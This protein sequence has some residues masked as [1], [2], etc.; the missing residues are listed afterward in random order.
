MNASAD[1]GEPTAA[2]TRFGPYIVVEQ[3]G[4]GGM[5]D[6]YRARDTRLNRDVA[7]KVIRGDYS[8]PSSRR[9]FEAEARAVAKL[10]HPNIV[11]IFDVGEERGNP[12]IVQE[13]VGGGTLSRWL[14]ERRPGAADKL[15]L[16]IAIAEGLA[17]AHRNGIVHR[18]LKPDNVLLTPDGRPKISDFGLAKSFQALANDESGGATAV[19]SATREGAFVGTP[20]YVSP[21]QATGAPLDA[22][23]DQFSFASMLVEMFGGRRPFE[24]ATTVQTLAAILHEEPDYGRLEKSV[25]EALLAIIRRCLAKEP[26]RRYG[27]TDDLLHDLR[28]AAEPRVRPAK[29][30]VRTAAFV[31][32]IALLLLAGVF[33]LW[34]RPAP[35]TA[36]IST[37][38]HSLA[39]LPLSNFSGDPSQ[40]YF[41][42]GMTEELT[43]QL[44]SL[45]S[46]RVVSR[47]SASAYRGTTKPL[48]AVAREL[49]VEGLIEGSVIRTGDRA[50]VTVQ[51]IDGRTDRHLWSQ[52]FD[53]QG[54]DVLTM[55]RDVAGQIADRIRAIVTPA[56][57]AR[58][59]RLPT[60]SVVAY[61]AFL[62]SIYKQ[63][64]GIGSGDADQ[65]IRFA[66]QA[67]AAD[68]NFAEAYVALARACQTKIFG[69]NGGKEYDEKGFIAVQKA[70]SL[71]P[72]LPDAYLA[73]GILH[74]NRWHDYDL[75]A[76]IADQRKAI[77][78]NANF[79]DAHHALG[80]DLTHV[81]LHDEAIRELQTAINLDPRMEGPKRRLGRPLWQSGRFTEALAAYERYGFAQFEKA[82]VLGYLGRRDE[83]WRVIDAADGAAPSPTTQ[84]DGRSDIA[85]ARALLYAFEHEREKANVQIRTSAEFGARNPHFHHAAFFL[86]AAC[87]ELS[88]PGEAVH[89]LEIVAS[90]G[91][92][93]LPLFRDNPSMQKL[94]GDPRY[95]RFL[96]DL[97][98][99]W[100]LLAGRETK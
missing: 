7:L 60:G 9:R 93:N 12:Y 95:E 90:T 66:E 1:A 10:S 63:T 49:G 43:S 36:P 40:D 80:A 100:D 68:P 37:Q 62:H 23:S 58:L 54:A 75:A 45:P 94:R 96:A 71:N 28:C 85:A 46:L 21:E 91:M 16:A 99:R 24:R 2:G 87:A 74:Y 35:A 34:H 81:G 78:L 92:P 26:A 13:L 38:P 20:A 53:R 31:T 18:D 61:D 30:S 69:W 84:N 70:L 56:D 50:R 64:T 44:A 42:E 32:A 67:I 17:E 77:S 15:A 39:I 6:V 29:R 55:Q 76:A 89:W 86:A 5:G 4:A 27:S 48:S 97:R 14:A 88:Q 33:F 83:A 22:R 11:S 72:Q 51:M 25:P 47:T 82:V 57:R 52:T 19:A 73:R 59:A 8:D 79:A 3:L 98:S 65:A 41:A